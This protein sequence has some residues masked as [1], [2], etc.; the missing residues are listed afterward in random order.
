MIS[1]LEYFVSAG[2]TRSAETSKTPTIGMDAI[3]TMPA[4]MLIKYPKTRS[5]L[6]PL[7]LGVRRKR[8]VTHKEERSIACLTLLS[9]IA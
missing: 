4:S 3:T 6:Q 8:K 9:R 1:R 5:L 2:R 7:V